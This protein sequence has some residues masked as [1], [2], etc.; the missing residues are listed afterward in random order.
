MVS[1]QYLVFG[2]E[3][4]KT[5]LST[6]YHPPPYCFCMYLVNLPLQQYSACVSVV[7]VCTVPQRG[8]GPWRKQPE[9]PLILQMG[10]SLS[11]VHH[12]VIIVVSCTCTSMY[13]AVS[14]NI[15]LSPKH[16]N[17]SQHRTGPLGVL[18]T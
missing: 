15:A 17:T 6:K 16:T 14:N 3:K 5:H 12:T 8:S 1:N 13:V 7:L 4:K 10:K 9:S 18:K 11:L 2:N